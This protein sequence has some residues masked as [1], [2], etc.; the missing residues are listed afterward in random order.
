MGLFPRA[1]LLAC[2]TAL[3]WLMALTAALLLLLLV[4]Q[5]VR[6]DAGAASGALLAAAI[7]MGAAGWLCGRAAA[8]LR[9]NS[10]GF[11]P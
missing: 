9:N 4:V 5:Q 11:G 2:L 10:G 7:G 8:W 1:V 6:G 3:R